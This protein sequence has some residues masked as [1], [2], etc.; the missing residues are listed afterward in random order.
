[1]EMPDGAKHR[2]L[3][4]K[5][6]ELIV[7]YIAV[8]HRQNLES[9]GASWPLLLVLILLMISMSNECSPPT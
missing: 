7:M 2:S 4:M 6:V 8:Y 1:M 3:L 5:P 9:I